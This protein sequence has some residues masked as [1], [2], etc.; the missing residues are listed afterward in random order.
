[1][2]I[3]TKIII[4]F[5]F[6][7]SVAVS[8]FFMDIHD[9]W[10]HPKCNI[11]CNIMQDSVLNKII[12]S[13]LHV[14]S[15][16]AQCYWMDILKLHWNYTEKPL[17]GVHWNYTGITLKCHWMDTLKLH[18][19]SSAPQMHLQRTTNAPPAHPKCTSNAP[20]LH[21]QRT[22]TAPP[23]HPKCTSSAPQTVH[24]QRTS[25]SA[26]PS[27]PTSFTYLHPHLQR[28]STAPPSTTTFTNPCLAII[29]EVHLSAPQKCTPPRVRCA[30]PSTSAHRGLLLISNHM[31]GK[32]W[33]E[34]TYPFLNF[35]GATVEV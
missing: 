19:T 28:T 16:Q 30:P 32:M 9:K 13:I 34:I 3:I 22:P 8:D 31:P 18:C 33:D 35:N 27:T 23:A 4:F 25:N 29:S 10:K 15:F 2:I 1:M 26:P 7:M 12:Q 24:L 11:F 17:D 14:L 6:S 21:L 20:Q 5:A